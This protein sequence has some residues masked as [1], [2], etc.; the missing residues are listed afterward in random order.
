MYRAVNQ[1]EGLGDKVVLLQ[2]V[3]CA[4]AANSGVWRRSAQQGLG[5]ESQVGGEAPQIFFEK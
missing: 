1:S 3:P 5:A 2:G 4:R